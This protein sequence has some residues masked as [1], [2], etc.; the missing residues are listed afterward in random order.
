MVILSLVSVVDDDELVRESLP[1]L[2][3]VFGD[4]FAGRNLEELPSAVEFG[5]NRRDCQDRRD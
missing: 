4:I 5:K 2:L 1:D 3:K